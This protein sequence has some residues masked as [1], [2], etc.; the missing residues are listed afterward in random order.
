[1][2]TVSGFLTA[3]GS[4]IQLLTILGARYRLVGTNVT[5]ATV[6]TGLSTYGSGAG[7]AIQGAWFFDFVGRSLAGRRVR[8][9]VFGAGQLNEGVD[10]RAQ[11]GEI[12]TL[13][14]AIS[15]LASAS[16]RFVAIDGASPVWKAYTNTGA[17]AYWRNKI[18][19]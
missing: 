18:R 16:N 6:W 14:A 2:S 15:V 4:Q 9:S 12:A 8:V 13:D 5:I 19:N 11:P 10:Y 7:T 17:N 3:L 1:M